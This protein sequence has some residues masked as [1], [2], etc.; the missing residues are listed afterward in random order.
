MSKTSTT[1]VDHHTDLSFLFNSH[2]ARIELVVDFID[3]LNLGIVVTSSQCTKL[4]PHLSCES[5]DNTIVI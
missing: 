2:L 1:A 3:D 5:Y 4:P